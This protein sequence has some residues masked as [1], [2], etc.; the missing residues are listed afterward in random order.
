[1]IIHNQPDLLGLFTP[2][3]VRDKK[4]SVDYYCRQFLKRSIQMFRYP[5]LPESIP[6]R[7]LEMLLQTAGFA[8]FTR[9]SVKKNGQSKVDIEKGTPYVFYGGLGGELNEYYNPTKATVANPFLN[10]NAELRD[11]ENCVIVYNDSLHQGLMPI[12]RRYA[13]QLAEND[14]TILLA[15]INTRIVALLQADNDPAKKEA[16]EYIKKIEEGTL[17]V[18]GSQKFVEGLREGVKSIPY[19]ASG[20]GNVLT[21]LIELEQYLKAGVFNDIGLNA[22]YNMK[23]ESINASEAQMGTDAL[24]PL[25]DDMLFSRRQG[26]KRVKEVLNIDVECEFGSAWEDRHDIADALADDEPSI[27]ETGEHVDETIEKTV[28]ETETKG[29]NE[30]V[31]ID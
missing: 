11:G 14:I 17:S 31:K 23:R 28:D 6:K 4:A 10:F 19:A 24:L 20:T 29:E 1:M 7:D 2:I 26:Y 30:N 25:T 13:T 27:D 16:D 18:V 15:D 21:Q 9:V 12:F 22:N 5:M 3:D 8:I